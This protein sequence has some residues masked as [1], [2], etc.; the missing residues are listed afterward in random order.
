MT[1]RT[2]E[3]LAFG[4]M[5]FLFAFLAGCVSDRAMEFQCE[6]RPVPQSIG[7]LIEQLGECAGGGR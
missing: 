2:S 3:F 1:P 6:T 4:V 5:L 7:Q